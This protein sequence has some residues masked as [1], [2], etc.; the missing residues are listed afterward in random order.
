MMTAT[1]KISTYFQELQVQQQEAKEQKGQYIQ[2][3]KN[4]PLSAVNYFKCVKNDEA[5]GLGLSEDVKA[6]YMGLTQ[7]DLYS[8]LDAA[9]KEAL[10][11][12]EITEDGRF[13]HQKA[14]ESYDDA[15]KKLTEILAA[16]TDLDNFTQR[17]KVTLFDGTP[18]VEETT[19][20]GIG[21]QVPVTFEGEE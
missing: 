14:A 4:S 11:I 9:E 6:F 15:I 1:D 18:V 19:A 12:V 10:H 13:I 16:K 5:V 3:V 7:A 2:N 8:Y 17:I 21:V 20:S